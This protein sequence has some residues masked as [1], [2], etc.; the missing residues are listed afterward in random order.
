MRDVSA[1]EILGEKSQ[2]RSLSP[3]FLSQLPLLAV[4]ASQ[5]TDSVV[6]EDSLGSEGSPENGSGE[7]VRTASERKGQF[8]RVRRQ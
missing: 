8:E 2:Q 1:R 7:A 4:P 5:L 6:S 3:P